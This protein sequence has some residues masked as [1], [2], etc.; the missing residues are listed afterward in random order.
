MTQDEDNIEI[1]LHRAIL[2]FL[3]D[4]LTKERHP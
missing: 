1:K 2:L 3:T 4:I